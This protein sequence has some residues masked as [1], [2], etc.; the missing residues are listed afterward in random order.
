VFVRGFFINSKAVAF[1]RKTLATA[2]TVMAI[3]ERPLPKQG[4]SSFDRLLI[5]DSSKVPLPD[6]EGNL[7]TCDKR[8][9]KQTV[10][11]RF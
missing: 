1:F 8:L 4:G 10:N 2:I 5:Q 11:C 9:V 6:T 3:S 7:P